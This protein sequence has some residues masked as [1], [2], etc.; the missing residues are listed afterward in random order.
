MEGLSEEIETKQPPLEHWRRF[1]YCTTL[2]GRVLGTVD[3][4]QPEGML[5]AI[6]IFLCFSISFGL[7]ATKSMPSKLVYDTLSLSFAKGL[8]LA[9]WVA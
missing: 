5:L 8:L 9:N 1:V 2:A 6:L 4:L 7:I 3:H